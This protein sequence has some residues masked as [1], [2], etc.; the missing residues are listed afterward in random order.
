M[1]SEQMTWGHWRTHGGHVVTV[2]SPGMPSAPSASC[3]Q[4]DPGRGSEE[5]GKWVALGGRELLP[6]SLPLPP[7]SPA[8]AILNGPE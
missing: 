8:A 1:S 5:P 7:S 3:A 4:E 2:G 6:L